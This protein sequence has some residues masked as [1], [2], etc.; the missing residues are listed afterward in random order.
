MTNGDIQAAWGYHNATK[1][2]YESVRTS[3]HIL[4]WKNYPRPFKIYSALE[5][6]PLPREWP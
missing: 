5:P 4:D 6:I 3:R 1:H 2:S